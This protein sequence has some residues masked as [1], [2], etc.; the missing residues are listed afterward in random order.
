MD[1]GSLGVNGED[2]AVA[3]RSPTATTLRRLVASGV[4]P[5]ALVALVA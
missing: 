4:A 1:V 2:R 5:L 3:G